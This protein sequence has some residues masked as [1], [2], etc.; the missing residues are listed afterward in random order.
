MEPIK[1]QQ[2]YDS[3]GKHKKNVKLKLQTLGS[4]EEYW[5]DSGAFDI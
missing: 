4:S 3:K 1:V 5:L 2:A